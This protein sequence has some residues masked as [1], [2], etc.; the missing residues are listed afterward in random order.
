MGA[1]QQCMMSYGSSSPASGYVDAYVT[2]SNIRACYGLDKLISGYSGPV[3]RVRRSS[4]NTE[5]DIGV[6]G[7]GDFDSAALATFVGSNNGFVSTWYDQSGNGEDMTEGTNR[8]TIV[9][10]GTFLGG[11]ECDGV[12][13]LLTC[14]SFAGVNT[15]AITVFMGAKLYTTGTSVV[16]PHFSVGALGVAG[17]NG[18]ELYYY[19]GVQLWS[20][21]S[22]NTSAAY[23][24]EYS[25]AG[26]NPTGS[27]H[28]MTFVGDRPVMPGANGAKIYIDGGSDCAGTVNGNALGSNFTG[29]TVN[30]GGSPSY[31]R[32]GKGLHKSFVI[33]AGDY[34]AVHVAVEALL[35]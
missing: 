33:C 20:L 23:H 1:V 29:V 14:S 3:V 28:S 25:M 10:S 9:S 5:Q 31:G 8:P 6:D 22:S 34:S 7:L 12:N 27:I 18:F 17:A 32:F 19:P 24:T 35:V 26:F 21:G 11:I 4:D 30:L 16:Y 15:P 13:D 2:G